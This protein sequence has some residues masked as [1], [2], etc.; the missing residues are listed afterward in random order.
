MKDPGRPAFL[1]RCDLAAV[2]VNPGRNF[3]AGLARRS[4]GYLHAVTIVTPA[5]LRILLIC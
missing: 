3:T 1:N 5:V 2:R 4:L